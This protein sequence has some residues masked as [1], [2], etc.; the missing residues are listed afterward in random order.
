MS[1]FISNSNCDYCH[2]KLLD[3]DYR[4]KGNHYCKKCYHLLFNLK[5]CSICNRKRKIF[6]S[7]KIPICKF[8]QVKGK[9]CIRCGK[10]NYIH[11]KITKN[12]PVCNS[13]IKYFSKYKTCMQCKKNNFPV[14]KRNLLN[15]E[16]K[17]LCQK[18]YYRTL[19]ICHHCSYR[20]KPYVYTLDKFPICKICTLE[21]LRKCRICKKEFPAG[22]GRICHNCNILNTLNKKNKFLSSSMS[23]S[24]GNYF[25]VFSQW[26]QKRRGLKFTSSHI[27]NYHEYFL[28]L[29][30]LHEQLKRLPTYEEIVSNYNV[31][32][33]RKNLSVTIFFDQKKL[34][35]ID[36]KI[37]E[38]YSNIN[39][40]NTYLSKFKENTFEYNLI[41]EYYQ[42]LH[43]KLTKNK[44]SIRSIRLALTPATKFLEYCENFKET[45]PNMYMLD[46]YLWLYPGQKCSIHGF[47]TFLSK[48][49]KIPL[50]VKKFKNP[51][52]K[53][54][55]SSKSQL[56]QHLINLLRADEKTIK[57][58]RRYLIKLSLGYLHGVSLPDNVFIS[59]INIK[60]NSIKAGGYLF[61]LPNR[62]IK[63]IKLK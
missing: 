45:R 37:K 6:H 40:I 16:K 27:Q 21:S 1:Y 9:A 18:C 47:I 3:W 50:S 57:I 41:N 22:Q 60:Q 2:N 11:G 53:R 54:H 51:I 13:C 4:Y 48:V 12:G 33:T 10:I 30:T 24:M 32:I 63:F 44:T 61:Y 28:K 7:L 43:L 5:I 49:L 17:L 14:S 25:N 62:I 42:T 29:D 56:Q 34:I 26:L 8:C 19:P 20:R 52:L 46:G 55:N 35:L 58:Q 31:Y 15:G 36:K 59:T 39:I 38:K 23:K